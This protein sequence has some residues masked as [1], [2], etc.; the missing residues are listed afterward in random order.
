MRTVHR[1]AIVEFNTHV[2]RITDSVAKMSFG[3]DPNDTK[4]KEAMGPFRN[5]KQFELKVLPL[6]QKGLQAYYDEVDKTT[7]S[8]HPFEA[9]I[10]LMVTYSIEV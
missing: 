4:V 3:A 1:D 8:I 7:H 2:K 6:L 5:P 9:K 10:S